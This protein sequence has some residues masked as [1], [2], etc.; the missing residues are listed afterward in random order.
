MG[1]KIIRFCDSCLIEQLE[2]L[3]A[4]RV[5]LKQAK[6]ASSVTVTVEFKCEKCKKKYDTK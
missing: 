6:K 2:E 1:V 4:N 3:Y 5:D